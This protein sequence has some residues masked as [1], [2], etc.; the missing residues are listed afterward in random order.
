MKAHLISIGD[1]LLNGQTVNTN[2][3]FIGEKLSDLGIDVIKISTISDDRTEIISELNLAADSADLIIMTGGL[4]PTNDDITKKCLSDYFESE[5]VVNKDALADV[6]LFFEKRNRPLTKINEDQALI[7]AIAKVLRNE[8]GTAP[9]MWIEKDEK[10][11]ISIP[12]VPFE[13]EHITTERIIPLL[14]D[15]LGIPKIF[16]KQ[17]MLLTTGIAESILYEKI[18][19]IEN[20]FEE[21]KIAF[22]PNEYG[23]KVKITAFGETEETVANT[24]LE[25]EQ[26][27]R[28]LAG[29]FIYGKNSENL[30]SVV[31]RLLTDRGLTLSIAESCTGGKIASRLTDIP[32]S[33]KFLERA[34]ITYSY[35]AKVE[36]LNV[37]E[38]ELYKNGAVSAETARQMAEGVRGIAGTDIG[39]A[40][41]GIMGPTG[42]TETK[43]LGLVY[44]GICDG[45]SC[46]AREFRFGDDRLLNKTRASQAA[47]EMVRRSILG[48][49]YDE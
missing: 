37:N 34:V 2:A 13:M 47:L 24:V 17:T 43:P 36:M 10:I 8:K 4:G 32:G 19:K 31:A 1:E 38:D 18:A 3:S 15:I 23:V 46:A 49:P 22:L 30:E 27:I 39:L 45:K 42:A 16:K 28:A 35:G 25:A 33:S 41:T 5:L 20:I 48:I 7:P 11:F 40:S 12:G 14:R 44:I 21:T 9:G 29:R 6:K 26:K